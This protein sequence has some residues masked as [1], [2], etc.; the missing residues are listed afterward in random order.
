LVLSRANRLPT[1]CGNRLLTMM[2]FFQRYGIACLLAD[3]WAARTA[4]PATIATSRTVSL[5]L[6][7]TLPLTA[8]PPLRGDEQESDSKHIRD[9]HLVCVIGGDGRFPDA[10]VINSFLPSGPEGGGASTSQG[11]SLSIF[12]RA[13]ERGN[14]TIAEA[15]AREL[16][17][18]SLTDALELTI[19]IACKDPRRHPRVAARWLL[20]YLEEDPETTIDEA[21]LAASCLAPLPGFGQ[22]DAAQVLRAMAE[23]ATRRR[24]ARG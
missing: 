13:I 24:G 21:A 18:V 8:A 7:S 19:L 17:R 22:A 3:A 11:H 6:I 5:R 23:R 14:L 15:T 16:L 9:P 4:R 10:H 12:R 1:P 20:R 2:Q